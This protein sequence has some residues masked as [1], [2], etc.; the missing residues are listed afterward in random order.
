MVYVQDIDGKPNTIGLNMV[1]KNLMFS[2]HLLF[3]KTL[4]L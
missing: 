1:L 2:M 4:M 3:L